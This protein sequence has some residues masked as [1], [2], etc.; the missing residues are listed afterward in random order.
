MIVTVTPPSRDHD[1]VSLSQ[2]KKYHREYFRKV[3]K[4]KDNLDYSPR[5]RQLVS[6]IHEALLIHEIMSWKQFDT[7]MNCTEQPKHEPRQSVKVVRGG[8]V[9]GMFRHIIDHLNEK[10]YLYAFDEEDITMGDL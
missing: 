7:V 3:K 6:S 9:D 5:T 4:V 2:I 8:T 10:H 1:W